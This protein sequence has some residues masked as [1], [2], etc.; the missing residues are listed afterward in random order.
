MILAGGSVVVTGGAVRIGKAI[1][2]SLAE[3]GHPVGLHFGSS[4]AEAE[5]TLREIRAQRG[6]AISIQADLSQP[7]TAAAAIFQ[8]AGQAFGPIRILIN[9]AATFAPGTLLNTTE[10]D[11]DRHLHINCKAPF[12]LT[13][14]FVRQLP[15]GTDGCVINILDW[16]AE[17]PIPGHAAYTVAKAGLLAQ[18][19]LLA[20]E[21][22][23]RV[24]VNAIA[25]GAILP[26]P[27]DSSEAFHRLGQKNPLQRVGSPAEIIRAVHYLLQA[28]F[29]TGE[30][31]HV[32]GGEELGHPV[33]GNSDSN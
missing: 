27:G 17:V 23:P 24:R 4:A 22:G 31:L 18:T 7:V 29:V 1:A 11:W 30:I 2:L 33:P 15:D 16:R 13:Q 8:Q 12:F 5:E 25:P 9:S 28:E 3:Q 14:Q 32:T 19:R 10:A 20:Q 21:L 6:S 26:A